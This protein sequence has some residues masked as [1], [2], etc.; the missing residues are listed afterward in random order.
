MNRKNRSKNTEGTKDVAALGL[1]AHSGWAALVVVTGHP[2][3]PEVIGRRR[4]EL[5]DSTIPGAGQ[6]YHTAEEMA[7][8]DAKKFIDRCIA[9]TSLLAR[10][11]LDRKS[12]RLNSSH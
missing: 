6:P 10:N 12:T 3:F 7:L 11:A 4:I 5:V 1:R 9:R 2:Q 8:K